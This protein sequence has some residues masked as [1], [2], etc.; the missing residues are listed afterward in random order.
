[1]WLFLMVNFVKSLFLLIMMF[2][3]TFQF[4]NFIHGLFLSFNLLLFLL[5]LFLVVLN[6]LFL[7]LSYWVLLVKWLDGTYWSL[8]WLWL[9]L[10]GSL[11]FLGLFGCVLNLFCNF[12]LLLFSSCFLLFGSL[13]F[14]NMCSLFGSFLALLLLLILLMVRVMM[15]LL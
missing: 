6:N 9:L 2:L 1:M 14:C 10:F 7:F 12:S 8:F 15:L 3:L 5:Q 13:F 11:L 4:S